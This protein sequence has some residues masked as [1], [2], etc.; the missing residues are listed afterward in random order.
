MSN[1]LRC[2]SLYGFVCLIVSRR[3]KK[4]LGGKKGGEK[5]KL[6]LNRNPWFFILR[7]VGWS[8]LLVCVCS[9]CYLTYVSSNK[10]VKHR[11]RFLWNKVNGDQVTKC[12][13]ERSGASCKIQCRNFLLP[14]GFCRFCWFFSGSNPICSAHACHLLTLQM[15]VNASVEMHAGSR[16]IMSLRIRD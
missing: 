5:S 8:W 11:G 1:Y 2:M 15:L 7:N 4:K 16:C 13:V 12:M 10:H 14:D 3:K 6:V 9:Y